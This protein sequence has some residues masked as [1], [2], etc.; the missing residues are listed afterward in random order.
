MLRIR[1]LIGLP[2]SFCE[3]A[4]GVKDHIDL[5]WSVVFDGGRSRDAAHASVRVL[6][7]RAVLADADGG[8]EGRVA[9]KLSFGLTSGHQLR[10]A[11]RVHVS[12]L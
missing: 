3:A 10:R 7:E 8:A 9:P 2:R 5:M 6:E 1:S 4:R 11:H 12:H